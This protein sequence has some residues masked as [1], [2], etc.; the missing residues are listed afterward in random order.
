MPRPKTKA[1]D[2]VDKERYI[3][4]WL[5]YEKLNFHKKQAEIEDNETSIEAV[6]ETD[7]SFEYSIA[8]NRGDE[9]FDEVLAEACE[10]PWIEAV[11]NTALYEALQSL[12]DEQKKLLTLIYADGLNQEQLAAMYGTSQQAISRRIL[13]AHNKIKTFFDGGL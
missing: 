12:S 7:K 4:K 13:R 11:Q 9:L 6:S 10:F 1:E 3:R 8:V 2:I 5:H